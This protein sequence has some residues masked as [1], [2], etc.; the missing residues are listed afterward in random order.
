[1]TDETTTQ[2]EEKGLSTG[3]KL[4]IA[5]FALAGLFFSFER[6]PFILAVFSTPAGVDFSAALQDI[7]F[8]QRDEEGLT[9]LMVA[10]RDGADGEMIKALVRNGAD[11][12]LRDKG[13]S[14]IFYAAVSSNLSALQAFIDLGVDVNETE[15]QTGEDVSVLMFSLMRPDAFESAKF[16]VK[17]GADINRK[18]K[19]GRTPLL[20]FLAS[21]W[22]TQK[23]KSL[24]DL[25]ANVDTTDSTGLGPLM[26]AIVH[27]DKPEMVKLFIDAGAD[28][29][30]REKRG[31][32]VLMIAASHAKKTPEVIKMLI[33]AGAEIDALGPE[34]ETA[35]FH[36][37]GGNTN[38]RAIEM[39]L[40]AGADL[41]IVDEV[42]DTP[43]K[44][45]KKNKELKDHPIQHRLKP[46]KI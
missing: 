29:N 35:I 3:F 32:T 46:T 6:D 36:A 30:A 28:M 22:S 2:E 10:A 42:N 34:K 23:I 14:A 43:Y 26:Y 24:I 33:D 44:M 4:F 7:D 12:S 1:M 19:D 8:N 27:D 37:A 38:P 45:I 16:L 5:F 20:F 21:G 13:L 41:T 9:P 31:Y 25:G 15:T 39:F 17:A 40:E 18:I 11:L